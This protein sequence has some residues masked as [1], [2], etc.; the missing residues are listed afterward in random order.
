MHLNPKGR[1]LIKGEKGLTLVMKK[2]LTTQQFPMHRALFSSVTSS[3]WALMMSS[4]IQVPA[5][6]VKKAAR[7]IGITPH[8]TITSDASIKYFVMVACEPQ[9]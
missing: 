1:E 8:F 5:R 2:L 4:L 6:S 7:V 9:N 3:I